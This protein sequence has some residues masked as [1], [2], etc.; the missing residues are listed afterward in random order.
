MAPKRTIVE[1]DDSDS[2]AS[3]KEAPLPATPIAPGVRSSEYLPPHL[4]I[5]PASVLQNWMNEFAKF[6]PGQVVMKYHGTQPERQEIQRKLRQCLPSVPDSRR[7]P[8]DVLVTTY[9]Y[10]ENEKP[11]D[12]NFLKKLKFSYMVL[13]EAHCL[14]NPAGKRYKSLNIFATERRILLTGTPIQNSPKELM[15]LLCFLMKGLFK[16][17]RKQGHDDG[18]DADDG[19]AGMLTHFIRDMK[20]GTEGFKPDRQ[21]TDATAYRDLRKLMAPFIL[22]RKKANVLSQI[23]P[24]K[25]T[26][27]ILCKFDSK[28]RA[29]YDGCLAQHAKLVSDLKLNKTNMLAA[30]KN[31]FS[32]LRKASNSSLMLRMRFKDKQSVQ[33]LTD[34]F[35]KAGFFGTNASCTPGMV[36]KQMDGMSDFDIHTAC[37]TLIDEF[38]VLGK[39]L[40]PFTL[41]EEDLYSG[42]PKMVKLRQFIP[43]LIGEGHRILLF[44]QWTMTMDLLEC[45]LNHLDIR[46]YRLDGGTAIGERQRMIDDFNG[47]DVPVFLLSTRAGGMGINLTAADTV[48]IHDLDFNP[49]MDEQAQDRCHRIGQKKPVTVYKMVTQDSVDHNIYKIQERKREVNRAITS[50]LDGNAKEAKKQEDSEISKMVADALHQFLEGPK[51][52]GEEEEEE[53]AAL[54]SVG[55]PGKRLLS[56]LKKICS[57]QQKEVDCIELLDSEEEEEEEEV[58]VRKLGKKQS[59]ALDLTGFS[60]ESE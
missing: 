46:F 10:F 24:P 51:K 11:D 43:K 32:S 37:L 8:L 41:Q 44:S 1:S 33:L 3:V 54:S 30:H 31:V 50:D 17:K 55:S 59:Q 49:T 39:T 48:I 5:V 52:E 28:T 29:V 22:R 15:A 6:S 57:S 20:H 35:F 18:N 56:P 38:P 47:N 7:Q 4:V 23:L 40:G 2:D 60:S 19:G 42:S 45:L 58:V 34:T 53:E 26:E 36:Q 13:D 25:T 9:S 27:L 16:K 21:T 14:K 12:R